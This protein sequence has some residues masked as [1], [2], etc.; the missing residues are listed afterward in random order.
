MTDGCEEYRKKMSCKIHERVHIICIIYQNI[1]IYIFTT[2]YTYKYM[3]YTHT[4]IYTY[5][6]YMKS[7]SYYITTINNSN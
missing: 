3:V 6:Y 4:Y 7:Y 5:I 1:Y 2:L